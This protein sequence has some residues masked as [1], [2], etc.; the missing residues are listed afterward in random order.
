MLASRALITVSMRRRQV[1]MP[2]AIYL[3]LIVLFMLPLGD[4]ADI[5]LQA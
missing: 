4:K 2:D 3:I 5:R 1:M